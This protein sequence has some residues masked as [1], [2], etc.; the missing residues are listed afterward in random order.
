MGSI[1]RRTFLKTASAT[2]AASP[3]LWGTS[4]SWAGANDRVRIG[5]IGI[6]GQGQAHIRQ[7]S[8]LENVEVSALCDV[9]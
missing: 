9:D 4:K 3:L 7:F 8:A 6:R 1:K 5:V 2:A